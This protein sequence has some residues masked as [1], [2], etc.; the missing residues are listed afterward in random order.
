MPFLSFA[1]IMLPT[2]SRAKPHDYPSFELW[3]RVY[4]VF[5]I[6]AM[7]GVKIRKTPYSKPL[8]ECGLREWHLLDKGTRTRY[9]KSAAQFVERQAVVGNTP[10]DDG[11][12]EPIEDPL[13]AAPPT[14]SCNAGVMG[15]PDIVIDGSNDHA[16][17]GMPDAM[18]ESFDHGLCM[19]DA[20]MDESSG[21]QSRIHD[22]VN[23]NSCEDVIREVH[24]ASVGEYC[25]LYVNDHRT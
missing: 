18:D 5:Q 13:P 11:P 12:S 6:I 24:P 21:H 17:S 20:I 8:L 16:G 3:G 25:K 4:N 1:V 7:S 14:I 10:S 19:P 9:R 15:M 2:T 23:G 22:A